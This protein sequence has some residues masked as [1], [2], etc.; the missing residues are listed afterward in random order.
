ME[1]SLLDFVMETVHALS[2]GEGQREDIEASLDFM[3]E[4]LEDTYARYEPPAPEGA[5]AIRELMLESI[6]LYCNALECLN[7]Y[8]E[9]ANPK[10]LKTAISAA[11]EASDLL[12]QV[13]AIVEESQQWLSQFQE[14]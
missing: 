1:N 2:L 10:L 5:E 9:R 6:D 14:Y 3:R 8:L 13:D 11:E 4:T 12:E 7:L